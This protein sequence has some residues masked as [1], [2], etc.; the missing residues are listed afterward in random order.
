MG[1]LLVAQ[2][3]TVQQDGVQAPSTRAAV[4]APPLGQ[5]RVQ[6]VPPRPHPVRPAH[7][8]DDSH[9]QGAV[10][11]LRAGGR[12]ER[13][14]G[15]ATPTAASLIPGRGAELRHSRQG[16]H[17]HEGG[18]HGGPGARGHGDVGARPQASSRPGVA[19]QGHQGVRDG[20]AVAEGDQHAGGAARQQL[21]RLAEGCGHHGGASRHGHQHGAAAGLLAGAVWGHKHVGRLVLGVQL[22]LGHIGGLELHQALDAQLLHCPVQALQVAGPVDGVGLPR[23]QQ[24]RGRD[25]GGDVRH[26]GDDVFHPLRGGQQ[27]ARQD[28]E[29]PRVH[30][31]GLLQRAP[32][33][34]GQAGHA[35]GH[36]VAHV[37]ELG[38]QPHAGGPAGDPPTPGWRQGDHRHA[39]GE[40]GVEGVLDGRLGG[41]LHGVQHR[42]Q[43]HR[44]DGLR[45]RHDVLP[46]EPPKNAVLVLQE[47]GRVALAG[48]RKGVSQHT[49]QAE[50][51]THYQPSAHLLQYVARRQR[52]VLRH[53]LVDAHD[54]LRAVGGAPPRAQVHGQ[55]V[56]LLRPQRQQAVTQAGAE[57]G[58]AALGGWPRAD[59]GV[60]LAP[61][62]TRVG[63]R[64]GCRSLD[65]PGRLRALI[66]LTPRLNRLAPPPAGLG[67]WLRD[68]EV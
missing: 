68:A 23:D 52:V 39:G 42:D 36:V 65:C 64:H 37:T 24:H 11:N 62:N 19:G 55:H 63:G 34:E 22:V 7:I 66:Q 44:A 9:S 60:A 10:P 14:A 12:L 35:V 43:G 45:Q 56:H 18:S 40:E 6:R 26:G 17:L 33:A 47:D 38:R 41:R 51:Q 20:A 25:A 32:G 5:E 46:P 57:G 1:A 67:C 2:E 28:E 4:A 27:A 48:R 16:G 53:I 54:H 61:G 29:S 30:T 49:A 58:Q 31:Q 13:Q 15:S 8:A 3:V 59:D 21:R 50:S